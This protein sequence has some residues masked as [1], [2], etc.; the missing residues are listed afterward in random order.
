MALNT[1]DSLDLHAWHTN[2]VALPTYGTWLAS[3]LPLYWSQYDCLR[4]SVDGLRNVERV[5][6]CKSEKRGMVR[7]R[8]S[9]RNDETSG[10]R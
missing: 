8:Q 3:Y 2:T 1:S 10:K 7:E 6:V 9:K 5:R 4:D